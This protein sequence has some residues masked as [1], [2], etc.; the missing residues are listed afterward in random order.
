M[1]KRVLHRDKFDWM[2]TYVEG[3]RVLDVGIVGHRLDRTDRPWLHGRIAEVADTV[4][5]LD[6]DRD[7]VQELVKR[8]YNVVVG[9]AQRF[10]LD[11]TFEV[12][13]ASDIVEHLA[14]FDGFFQSVLPVLD[15]NGVLLI[16]TPNAFSLMRI[17]E[18]LVLGTVSANPQHTCWLNAHVLKQLALRHGLQA[19]DVA[20]IEDSRYRFRHRSS[21]WYPFRLLN[22]LSCRVR[23]GLAET[24]GIA[25]QRTAA[26]ENR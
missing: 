21:V 15:E 6:R 5:G 11:S 7:G 10:T 19:V 13:V 14:N 17:F 4:V 20:F 8:G 1:A 23:T 18:K 2:K 22:W 9:D 26:A 12:V 24:L 16:T 3:K 25:F